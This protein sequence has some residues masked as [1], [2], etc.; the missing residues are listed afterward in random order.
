MIRRYQPHGNLT[1]LIVTLFLLAMGSFVAGCRADHRQ[2]T[3]RATLATVHTARVTF[4]K[5][6][7]DHQQQIVDKATSLEDGRADLEAYRSKRNV[8]LQA[9]IVAATLL[10]TAANEKDDKQLDAA[11]KAVVALVDDLID[12]GVTGL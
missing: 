5:W 10:A 3:I 11:K 9:F 7:R 2:T 6:D 8:V 1:L 12:L 4:E